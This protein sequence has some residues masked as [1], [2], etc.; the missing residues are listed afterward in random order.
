MSAVL[1]LLVVATAAKAQTYTV[2]HYFDGR[3]G[4]A[5]S[6]LLAQGRDGGLYGTTEEGGGTQKGAV[7]AVKTSGSWRILFRFEGVHG[8]A[9]T[10]GLTLGTD[11][12]FYGPTLFG[13]DMTCQPGFGCGTIFRITGSG[14]LTNLYNF[15]NPDAA[16][17]SPLIQ[18]TDGDFYSSSTFAL[19]YKV[20][21]S[22]AFTQ[23]SPYLGQGNGGI[24][25]ATDGNLYGGTLNG[26]SNIACSNGCGVVYQI[27]PHGNGKIF[28]DFDGIHGQ[29]PSGLLIQ[30]NDGNFYGTAQGGG[31]YGGG[32]VFKLTPSAQIMVLHNFADPHDPG[33]GIL[34]RSGLLQA[35]D[36]NF[37]GTT[38]IGGTANS[39]VL[40]QITPAGS[41]SILH[42]FDS[43]HGFNPRLVMQH[44]NGKIYGLADGGPMNLGLL[45]SLDAGLNPFIKLVSSSAKVGIPIK[46]LGQGFTGTTNVSFNG[47]PATFTVWSD[48]YLSAKVPDGATIGLVTVTTATSMLTSNREFRVRPVIVNV[49]PSS[50]PAGT[51]VVITGTSF[52]QTTKLVIGGVKATTFTVDSDSQL[53][54]TVPTGAQTGYIVLTTAGGRSRSPEIFTATP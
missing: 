50:A 28:Y 9:P 51:P 18:G 7:F 19:A 48:T 24:L 47:T 4:E 39:G 8:A 13:G 43:L 45:Y 49:T 10:S 30:A 11:G 53:T 41:Y 29:A 22:G 31:A 35:S 37:Y 3:N 20:T 16:G 40:F 23:F 5:P 42:N 1:A 36:G 33:D 15:F 52:S 46:I 44:T 27:A 6:G 14:T 26:G 12:A 17:S 32:V 2:V 25:Q 54:A 21:P 38:E 34:P